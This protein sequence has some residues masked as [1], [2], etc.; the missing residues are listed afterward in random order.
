MPALARLLLI[1][2]MSVAGPAAAVEP[3]KA[4]ICH[5]CGKPPAGIALPSRGVMFAVS[6]MFS[7]GWHAITFDRDRHT[8]ARGYVPARIAGQAVAPEYAEARLSDADMAELD[9]VLARVWATTEAVPGSRATD[10]FWDLWLVDGGQRRHETGAGIASG[11]A[12]PLTAMLQRLAERQL[13]TP[14]P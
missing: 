8:I 6:G 2:C 12:A 14:S 4:R 7:F 3:V 5:D 11:A 9:A 13:P 1:A 10:A